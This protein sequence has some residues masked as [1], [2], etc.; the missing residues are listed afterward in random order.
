MRTNSSGVHGTRAMPIR[1]PSH[2]RH[3]GE[4]EAGRSAL[5][6][7]GTLIAWRDGTTASQRRRRRGLA[8]CATRAGGGGLD[9]GKSWW[10]SLRLTRWADSTLTATLTDVPRSTAHRRNLTS[11]VEPCSKRRSSARLPPPPCRVTDESVWTSARR[12]EQAE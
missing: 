10:R 2:Q 3:L 6:G 4:A 7:P 8:R 1:W 12:P 11:T 9:G 5:D